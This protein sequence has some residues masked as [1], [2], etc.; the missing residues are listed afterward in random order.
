MCNKA[1]MPSKTAIER[2]LNNKELLIKIF[3]STLNVNVYSLEHIKD[4]MN[5][6]GIEVE[7]EYYQLDT[8]Q[9]RI[10]AQL[11]FC[12]NREESRNNFSSAM[13]LYNYNTNE[14][15]DDKQE[16]EIVQINLVF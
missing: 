14:L 4:V 8:S 9:G 15:G 12:A 2:L 16:N 5:Y 7:V 10:N 13:N 11:N 3:E 6:D 1:K